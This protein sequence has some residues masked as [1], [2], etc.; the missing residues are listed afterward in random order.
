MLKVGAKVKV[1]LKTSPY[2]GS[3]GTITDVVLV[4]KKYVYNVQLEDGKVTRLEASAL[5]QTLS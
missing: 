2:K 4:G 1:I 5:S 3:F